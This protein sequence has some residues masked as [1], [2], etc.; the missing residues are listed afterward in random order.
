M[1]SLAVRQ[2]GARLEDKVLTAAVAPHSPVGPRP[3]QGGY[4]DLMPLPALMGTDLHAAHFPLLGLAN[5]NALSATRRLACLSVYGVNL[6]QQRLV[7]YLTRLEVPTFQL[8]EAFAHTYEAADA[9]EEWLDVLCDA[10]WTAQEASAQFE[11]FLRAKVPGGRAL[12]E[13]LRDP[14][15]R[16]AVRLACRAKARHLALQGAPQSSEGPD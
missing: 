8:Q 7:W 10:G 13:D 6:L 11:S 15:R 2:Q 1:I 14:E 3:W 9:L 4:Y 16:S 5:S 12:Q